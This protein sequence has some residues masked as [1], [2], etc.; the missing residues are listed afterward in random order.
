MRS[1]RA[2]PGRLVHNGQSYPWS[3]VTLGLIAV[4]TAHIV[5]AQAQV[6]P[7]ANKYPVAPSTGTVSTQAFG[8]VTSQMPELPMP[9]SVGPQ[10]PIVSVPAATPSFLPLQDTPQKA[11]P[12][13]GQQP[14]PV[15]LPYPSVLS[16]S[17][18]FPNN[19]G[20]WHPGMGRMPGHPGVV[21][22]MPAPTQQ[23]V[24]MYGKHIKGLIDPQ[25]NL[26]LAVG[27]TRLMT[28]N[29]IPK[30]VQVADEHI[31]AYTVISPT[32]IS[33]LGKTV[34]VTVLTMWFPDVKDASKQEVLTYYVRV[35][36]DPEMR[37][38][39]EWVY[40][41]LAEEINRAFPDSSVCLNLVG[42]KVVV[43]GY[44]K[45]FVDA[46]Q[47]I[48]LVQAQGNNYFKGGIR[49]RDVARIP[50]ERQ[51]T[52]PNE[53]GPDGLP[54]AGTDQFEVAG[55]PYVVNL[56]KVAGDQQ[57]MLRVTVAEVNRA[58]ARSI[59]MNFTINGQVGPVVIN[60]TGNIAQGSLGQGAGIGGAAG[61]LSGIT[62]IPAIAQGLG[63]FNNLAAS[64]DRG[65]V[66][67]AISALRELNYARS[68]AE[69]NL[70]ALNGQ[71]AHFHA[72][73]Q[74]PVPTLSNTSF[75]NTL[76]GVS[77]VPYGVQLS[78]TP[79]ILDRN[80]IRLVVAADVTT[81][82]LSQGQVFIGGTEVPNL[83]TRSFQTTVEL[84][85]GQTLA[86]AGL[87]QSNLGGDAAKIPW[88][89]DLPYIGR[90]FSFDRVSAGEQELMVLIT[91]Q[92]VQPMGPK[93]VPAL[94]GFDLFEPT[95]L[96]FYL[97]GRIE[98]Q[99]MPNWRSPVRTDWGR[100]REGFQQTELMYISGP[101]GQ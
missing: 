72:G 77:F 5:S 38:H 39:L 89:G 36:P 10:V 84:C 4:M 33:L 19:F 6:P 35:I 18:G 96:E 1:N 45:D 25:M 62:P 48:K 3:R 71:T 29:N 73:G 65:Q 79:Y 14:E 17:N 95:D 51:K 70:T 11:Q 32:E 92:L 13:P 85:E 94:P 15:E 47:I 52:N 83:N 50:V 27:R 88:L 56:L 78:F 8:A 41:Q 69:P 43:S 75:T 81:R 67:V 64:L 23:T 12:K 34:G 31:A 54:A 28:L 97:L 59:G 44:A 99:R 100:L 87:I 49:A 68:L 7:T 80:C 76:Q 9:S 90:L 16:G 74:F 61:L 40:S 82:D 21:G 60:N 22:S 30:R 98:G 46:G 42:D 26:D 101:H 37:K 2:T 55:A 53:L 66:L 57:V 58:A 91:P 86:V 24:E 63:G 20:M 93:D